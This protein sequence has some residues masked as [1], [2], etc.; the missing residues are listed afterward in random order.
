MAPEKATALQREAVFGSFLTT[1]FIVK[2]KLSIV[3]CGINY[4]Q[5]AT[6]NINK[7]TS[8]KGRHGAHQQRPR[9]YKQTALNHQSRAKRPL[10]GSQKAVEGRLNQNQTGSQQPKVIG[11]Q[12][13]ASSQRPVAAA[14]WPPPGGC[15]RV[16][17]TVW[18]RG[19]AGALSPPRCGRRRVD[20]AAWPP[21]RGCRCVADAE[22]PSR[23]G[24]GG[25]AAATWR[26]R[27]LRHGTDAAVPPASPLLAA[28]Y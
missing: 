15:R 27:R 6:K 3:I 25:K 4:T 23:S 20:A 7:Q 28:G 16:A 12:P 9:T 19:V 8:A 5:K 2:C 17:A 11:Q 13:A 18:R 1:F 10:D 21:P 22:R 14:L 24:R 26:P